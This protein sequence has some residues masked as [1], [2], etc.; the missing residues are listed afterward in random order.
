PGGRA[1]EGRGDDR[2]RR[3]GPDPRHV[4]GRLRRP[5]GELTALL[6]REPSAVAARG[7]AFSAPDDDCADAEFSPWYHVASFWRRCCDD[8]DHT[9]TSKGAHVVCQMKRARS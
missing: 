9:N 4:G 2:R 5:G 1:A 7:R 8:Q 6:I 3:A